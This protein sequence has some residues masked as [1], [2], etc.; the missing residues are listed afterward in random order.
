[1]SEP[2]GKD[3]FFGKWCAENNKEPFQYVLGLL[4][5]LRNP[6]TEA[7]ARAGR[8]P[9]TEE[10]KPDVAEE[11]TIAGQ[12][13]PVYEK[14]PDTNRLTPAGFQ[15]F[16]KH[17]APAV[18]ALADN[19]EA[20]RKVLAKIMRIVSP[21]MRRNLVNLKGSATALDSNELHAI[22]PLLM[23][24][25]FPPGAFSSIQSYKDLVELSQSG[26]NTDY[27]AFTESLRIAVVEFTKKY[28]DNSMTGPD[29]ARVRSVPRGY[30]KIDTL[31]ST[32]F[33][34]AI[35][36]GAESQFFQF[37]LD[38]TVGGVETV[39]EFDSPEGLMGVFQTFRQNRRKD[40]GITEASLA[41]VAPADSKATS[42]A[43]LTADKTC[44][45]CAK[46]F[47]PDKP[48]YTQ[49]SGCQEVRIAKNKK[50]RWA[51]KVAKA[52]IAK[53]EKDKTVV[54]PSPALTTSAISHLPL[55]HQ[56][57]IQQLMQGTAPA[58]GNTAGFIAGVAGH[59]GLED[60]DKELATTFDG[61]FTTPSGFIAM[62]TPPDPPSSAPPTT[63]P[64]AVSEEA[65]RVHAARD[66]WRE[67]DVASHVELALALQLRDASYAAF[68]EEARVISDRINADPTRGQANFRGSD[69]AVVI[70]N[71]VD[72]VRTEVNRLLSPTVPPSLSPLPWFE[73]IAFLRMRASLFTAANDNRLLGS[74]VHQSLYVESAGCVSCGF[75]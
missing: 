65:A 68:R 11:R 36:G 37:L 71:I 75:S 40:T 54:V 12:Q 33:L 57:L 19:L 24:A 62:F 3:R 46:K 21:E 41:F 13:Y 9:R 1:M 58:S 63:G 10:K 32:I 29:D 27:L 35:A 56:Q 39:H 69:P 67:N 61:S 52:L 74:C 50:E 34:S 5:A 44:G 60:Y 51:A 23:E 72:P 64:F 2:F 49:C 59:I 25:V 8:V 53:P 42:D 22:F 17:E 30:V 14:D 66:A 7:T 47:T 6:L 48:F 73:E 26:V 31:V 20:E 45:G 70:R 55:Q 16:C 38:K 43:K 28:E 4:R 15:L 18:A